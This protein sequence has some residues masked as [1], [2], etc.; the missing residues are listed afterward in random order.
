MASASN[1]A[2]SLSALL[3]KQT[4]YLSSPVDFNSERERDKATASPRLFL[5]SVERIE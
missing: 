5:E 1:V 2:L 4:I 3:G